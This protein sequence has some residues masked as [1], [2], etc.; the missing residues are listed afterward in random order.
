MFNFQRNNRTSLVSRGKLLD[1]AIEKCFKKDSH[2]NASASSDSANDTND[3]SDALADS[4][5]DKHSDTTNSSLSGPQTD[6][7]ESP[8]A[9]SAD[10][11]T[12]YL[13]D[14]LKKVLASPSFFIGE[15][16]STNSS[17]L[18]FF[19]RPEVLSLLVQFIISAPYDTEVSGDVDDY[20][21][22]EDLNETPAEQDNLDDIANNAFE[23][24]VSGIDS[25]DKALL[26]NHEYLDQFWA[27]LDL[28]EPNN[29]KISYLSRITSYHLDQGSPELITYIKQQSN[30]MLRFIKHIENPPV[31][32]VLLK[33]ISSDNPENPN[34]IIEFLQYQ[35]LI[36][37]FIER[38]GPEF[39]FS[40][41]SASGDFIK[42]LIGISANS[43]S[44]HTNIGPNELTRELVSEP[45]INELVRL[46]LY[47]GSSLSTGVGIVIEIIRKNNSDYDIMPVVY[48]SIEA[49][50]PTTRDPIY[51]GTLL[52]VFKQNMPKFYD[53]LIKTHDERLKT[54][55]G[56]I[57]PLGFER[58]KVCE[59]VAELLHCSN[60]ALL[61]DINGEK[62]VQTRDRE[63][64]R[65]RKNHYELE[66]GYPPQEFLSV[67]TDLK[68]DPQN[69]SESIDDKS[70]TTKDGK[71]SNENTTFESMISEGS[72]ES[73]TKVVIDSNANSDDSTE[74]S[75]KSSDKISNSKIQVEPSQESSEGSSEAKVE[76]HNPSIVSGDF[77][78]L[79][80]EHPNN[81][82]NEPVVIPT[83]AEIRDN[84]VIGDQVKIAFYDTNI[85]DKI[86][87]MFFEFPWNNFLHNVVFDIVQQILNG[88]MDQ[89]FNRYLTTKIFNTGRITF[90]IS[91]CEKLCEKYVA[92]HNTRLGYMGHLTLISEAIVK[93]ETTIDISSFDPVIKQAL[94]SPEWK[95]YIDN[96]LMHTREQYSYILGGEIPSEEASEYHSHAIILRND[97][98][99]MELEEDSDDE[100]DEEEEEE[101]EEY[102]S[103]SHRFVDSDNDEEYFTDDSN[104]DNDDGFSD[105]DSED[106]ALH[107]F[108]S[109]HHMGENNSSETEDCDK[110][111]MPT[112]TSDANDNENFDLEE[113]NNK[114]DVEDYEDEEDDGLSLVRSKSHNTEMDWDLEETQKIVETLQHISHTNHSGSN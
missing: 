15:L 17:Y 10:D 5:F 76:G 16:L 65:I 93:F 53:I 95:S 102:R 6:T 107:P 83:E 60:M 35:K 27:I 43:N 49:R 72:A 67:I 42:A 109:D 26:S 25:L 8:E 32:D 56:Q 24:F 111:A 106:H 61:N 62:M 73:Q 48:F 36:S 89:G 114:D 23:I 97:D 88:P 110:T 55:F 30:F 1:E 79:S 11:H 82:S 74:C 68:E 98:Q 33:I 52:K 37:L 87:S 50:P 75:D 78:S 7:L 77:Q 22:D 80:L 104:T 19:Q 46:M 66:G 81:S 18:D 86:I 108:H 45:C 92:K 44:D 4:G 9:A 63:R 58:F 29:V 99:P 31:M 57:E 20:N 38:I 40:V 54:A 64:V 41:Q 2:V 13:K 100:D 34:G 85:V 70:G 14:V 12:E 105:S 96:S 113:Y 90:L 91:E 69:I 101:E 112:T 94:E 103:G 39:S 28:E 59:L 21:T 3:H 51:L 71:D 47:G 84:P